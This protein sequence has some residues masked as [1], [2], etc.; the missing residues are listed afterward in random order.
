VRRGFRREI[1]AAC[2]KASSLWPT[3][4]QL[5][6][7][8]NLRVQRLLRPEDDD[9]RRDR[10]LAFAERRAIRIATQNGR[11]TDAKRTLLTQQHARHS[12]TLSA[13]S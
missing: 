3:F 7:N 11:K 6:L 13:A 12:P 10:L 8:G 5:R 2:L 1:T 9:A 4:T